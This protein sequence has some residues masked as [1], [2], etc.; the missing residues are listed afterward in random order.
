ML[1]I[2]LVAALSHAAFS[3]EKFTI[4]PENENQLLYLIQSVKAGNTIYISASVGFSR[5]SDAVKSAYGGIE[6]TLVHFG[7][8]YPDV[9]KETII[10][11]LIV[12]APH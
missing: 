10:I 1:G 7:V 8:S 12:N 4:Y 5:M 9:I 6:K 3:Q 2:L 11:E